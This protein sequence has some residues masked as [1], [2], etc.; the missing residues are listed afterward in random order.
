MK[1]ETALKLVEEEYER[2]KQLEFVHNPLAYALYKTWKV[3]DEKW[4]GDNAE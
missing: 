3:V 1:L 2:A 4:G